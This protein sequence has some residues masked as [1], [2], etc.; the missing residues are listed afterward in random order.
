MKYRIVLEGLS[1]EGRKWKVGRFSSS[2]V[3][4]GLVCL[5]RGSRNR[6]L[7][8]E[9]RERRRGGV[10][11]SRRFGVTRVDKKGEGGKGYILKIDE[12]EREAAKARL[13]GLKGLRGQVG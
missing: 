2:M 5:P 12:R 6:F 4:V 7:I 11:R 1:E 13:L 10:S 9:L 8:W 3:A